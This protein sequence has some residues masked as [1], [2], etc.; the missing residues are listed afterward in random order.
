[1][2]SRFMY[3]AVFHAAAESGDGQEQKGERTRWCRGKYCIY[4]KAF[5][6]LQIERCRRK[7][8]QKIS[9][10]PAVPTPAGAAASVQLSLSGPKD[11]FPSGCQ[12]SS[13]SCSSDRPAGREK[14]VAPHFYISRRFICHGQTGSVRRAK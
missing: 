4:M 11:K 12:V 9:G 6:V 5:S 8:Q 3:V 10:R 7:K 1:M 14:K 2:F 13:G